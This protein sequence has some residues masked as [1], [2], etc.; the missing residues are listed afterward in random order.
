M[1]VAF[2]L[3]TGLPYS[4]LE[5][6]I[7]PTNV[8]VNLFGETFRGTSGHESVPLHRKVPEIS[9]TVRKKKK[10]GTSLIEQIIGNVPM[11]EPLH[12]SVR[13]SERLNIDQSKRK[14]LESE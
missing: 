4:H 5:S 12:E 10:S 11:V 14:A 3:E 7:E 1:A 6:K 13:A 2:L 8:S 9:A